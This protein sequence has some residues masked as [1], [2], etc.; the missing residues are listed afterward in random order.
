MTLEQKYA[1]PDGRYVVC[2][3]SYEARAFQWVDTPEL[4]DTTTGRALLMLEDRCWHVDEAQWSGSAVIMR[5]RHFPDGVPSYEVSLDCDEL[6]VAVDG[7]EARPLEQLG[8]VLQTA[9]DSRS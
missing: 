5:L 7:R 6:T 3:D 2:V 9:L 1:S 8:E 4:I